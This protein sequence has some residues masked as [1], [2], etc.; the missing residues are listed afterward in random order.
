MGYGYDHQNSDE[1]KAALI[2]VGEAARNENKAFVSFVPNAEKAKEWNN[3]F[4]I[5][6]FFIASEHNWLR[7]TANSV[8][9]KTHQI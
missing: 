6:M 3:D 1:L 4:G 9:E 7:E 5:T 8:A 2:S